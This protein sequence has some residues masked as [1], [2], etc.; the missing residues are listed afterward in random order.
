[1]SAF[2]TWHLPP[3]FEPRPDEIAILEEGGH[4]SCGE[5]DCRYLS[6]S[7]PRLEELMA[8]L[9][10]NWDETVS[11]VPSGHIVDAVDGVAGRLLDSGD[12]LR[13]RALD[14]LG[15]FAGFSQAMAET[16]LEGM[17]RGWLREGLWDLIRS[18]FPDP[19][20][21]DGFRPGSG[22]SRTRALGFPLVFHLGAGTVPGVC[23]TS[24]IRGLLVKSAGLLKPGSGDLPLSLLFAQG[25]EEE[26]PEL[27]GGIAVVY[28][29]VSEVG[30]T[31]AALS[32]ADLAVAYGSDETISWVRRRLP[33]QTPLRGYRHRMGFGLVGTR[34]LS[35]G[36]RGTEEDGGGGG[37][38]S[39]A[40]S[41]AEKAARSVALFDQRGCVSPHVFFVERGGET[42]PR[43]W[44][45]LLADALEEM[46]GLLPS[47]PVPAEEGVAIQ[48][49]RGAAE[50]E[51]TLG[52]TMVLHGGT[53]SSWTV[54]FDEARRVEPSCLNRTVRVLPVD[55]HEDA[56]R[57]LSAWAPYLQTLG[58]AGLNEEMP[59]FAEGLARLGVSRITSIEGIPW[60]DPWWHH[61]GS[62]P[63]RDLAR[64][65]DAEG[66]SWPG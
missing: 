56:L 63:L 49:L 23:A 17:A 51:E 4:P 2:Q 16:V 65:I 44:A 12:P 62:G 22:G 53:E 28:W 33:P 36:S 31:E 66:G 46:E 57:L 6:L 35:I 50:L 11:S 54:V 42:A 13:S 59:D 14:T 39:E 19:G 3:G 52:K 5:G 8:L 21:L 41:V 32:R 64:W 61:D 58:V 38:K 34:A 24:L 27:A 26:A 7:E 30:R 9:R 29:P 45:V 43:E 40:R 25:L 55:G 18:E 60:P 37:A 20:V 1:M 10:S 47:G 15:P 48:Q